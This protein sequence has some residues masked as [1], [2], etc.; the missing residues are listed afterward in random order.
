MRDGSRRGGESYRG[1]PKYEKNE[2]NEK[3]QKR[4]AD[5]PERRAP[6]IP[7]KQAKQAA[8]AKSVSIIGNNANG[9]GTRTGPGLQLERNF[10]DGLRPSALPLVQTN[11]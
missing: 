4:R 2:R 8:P 5:G 9:T 1:I 11:K 6:A 3:E 7:A 10:Y